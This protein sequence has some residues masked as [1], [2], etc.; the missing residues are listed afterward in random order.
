MSP[1]QNS[2]AEKHR[3]HEASRKWG[4]ASSVVIGCTVAV[5][6]ILA[7]A[8]RI[9]LLMDG[10]SHGA[11]SLWWP[12]EPRCATAAWGDRAEPPQIT[13]HVDPVSGLKTHGSEVHTPRLPVVFQ[14]CVKLGGSPASGC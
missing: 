7:G 4:S 3:C 2:G 5:T 10:D 9:Y 12:P 1:R 6:G 14:A 8:E 11:F 13:A